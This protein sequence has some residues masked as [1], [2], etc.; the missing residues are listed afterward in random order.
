MNNS[1]YYLRTPF[2]VAFI[3]AFFSTLKTEAKE[4]KL[5]LVNQLHDFL[6]TFSFL[7]N[8]VKNYHVTLFQNLLNDYQQRAEKISVFLTRMKYSFLIFLK[9]RST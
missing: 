7:K 1:N 9:C 8:N 6:F 2:I 4:N 3:A 5:C